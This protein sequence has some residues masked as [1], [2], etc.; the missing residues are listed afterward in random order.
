MFGLYFSNIKNI[1]ITRIVIT[2]LSMSVFVLKEIHAIKG[3]KHNSI[4]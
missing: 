1:Y 4:N 3:S 2:K